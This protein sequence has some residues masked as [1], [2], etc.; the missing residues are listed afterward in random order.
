MSPSHVIAWRTIDS[1]L[2]EEI[3]RALSKFSEGGN[4][5]VKTEDRVSPRTRFVIS[6]LSLTCFLFFL[7]FISALAVN[8]KQQ[9]LLAPL[10]FKLSHFRELTCP[11]INR[12]FNRAEHTS[13]RVAPPPLHIAVSVY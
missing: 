6:L 2:D 5:N 11:V 12:A 13:R 8:F 9:W 1:Y 4:E 10:P 7:D 3:N